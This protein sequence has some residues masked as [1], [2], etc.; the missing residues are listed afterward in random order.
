MNI[1]AVLGAIP[2]LGIIAGLAKARFPRAPLIAAGVVIGLY[3]LALA[4]VGSWAG[5]CWD[6]RG[7][8]ETRSDVFLV[9]A[10]WLGVL[11]FTTLLGIWL[12]ARMST[13]LGRLARTARELWGLRRPPAEGNSGS[14][15]LKRM[16][17]DGYDLVAEAYLEWRLQKPKEQMTPHLDKAIEG[18]RSGARALDL[19][20]GAGTPYG[21]YLSERVDVL[22]VD[23]SPGQLALARQRVPG[24]SFALG[25]MGTVEFAQN[26][27]DLI[28]A[29]YSIIHLPRAE[30]EPL[31]ARLYG[32]LRPGGR[33]LAVLGRQDWEGR[34]QDWLAPG[35]EMFWS[36]YGA[37]I[38]LELAEQAGF[39][40]VEST[41]EPDP[42]GGAHLFVL[43]EK[44]R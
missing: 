14:S 13:M 7:L 5:S 36:H 25:D 16:V 1:G 43:A 17:A 26:S 39:R 3:A 40:V 44:P 35:V 31:F 8:S 33:L 29:L 37:D 10:I 11:V 2:I 6:C 21:A 24:A 23:I 12:G 30:H 15:D 9:L 41:I 32:W 27:F 19:G 22:G 42:M 34:E 28:V 38:N 4:V 18:L 20:C